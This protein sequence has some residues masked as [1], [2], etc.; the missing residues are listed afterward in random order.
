M[1]FLVHIGFAKAA[2]TYLQAGLFSGRH[3]QIDPLGGAHGPRAEALGKCGAE[4]FLNG[5]QL[6]GRR[7]RVALPFGYDAQAVRAEL[8]AGASSSK[9]V[10]VIS[11]EALAGHPYSGGVGA[12]EVCERIHAALPGARILIVLR[13]QRAMLLS[14]YADYL[15]RHNGAARLDAYLAPVRADQIPGHTPEFYGFSRLVEG[16]VERFGARNVLVVPMEL[17]GQAGLDT[18]IEGFLGVSRAEVAPPGPVNARDYAT[19]AALRLVTFANML[20]KRAAGNG[21]AALGIPALRSLIVKGT[22]TVLTRGAVARILAADRARI[23]AHL[24]PIVAEDNR[25]L[26]RFVRADLASLGYMCA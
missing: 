10:T 20:G 23:E 12:E 21:N 8:I 17:L 4:L 22:R 25:R 7:A 3:P 11:D 6:G 13:E 16:Y 15:V 18:E 1:S 14:A 19:Y 5:G 24:A 2:S 9:P 26:Q